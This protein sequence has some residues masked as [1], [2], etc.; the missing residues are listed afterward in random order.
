MN[1]P[2]TAREAL[3]VEALREVA[4]L[5]DRIESLP[6]SMEVGRL[7]LANASAELG[8]RLKAFEAGIASVS[9][10]VQASAAEQ[11]VRRAV[12]ATSD[13]IETQTRAMNA[14]ARLAFST[15]VDSTLARLTASLQQVLHRVD[16]PW[17]LWL[18]HAATAAASAAVTWWVVSS[19]AFR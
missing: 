6:S 16:R 5:L 14:A 7:A 17:D 11:L 13:S 12:K 9:Q 4:H 8:D 10:K 2:T 3:I 15:Q 18:T 1:G 19:F